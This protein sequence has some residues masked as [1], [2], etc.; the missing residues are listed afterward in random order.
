MNDATRDEVRF[1]A[2]RPWSRDFCRIVSWNIERGL[3][4]A[5]ILDFLRTVEADLLLLQEVDLNAR[6]TQYRD[7]ASDL[8][9]SLNFNYVFGMEFQE[10]SEGTRARPAFHGMATLSPWPLTKARLI[11]FHDQ[12]AF[13]KPHW[14]VPD[15]PV[16]QRRL[17]GRIALVAEAR[18]Y[19]QHVVT[20]NLHLESRGTDELRFRQLNDVLA[21]CRN[22]LN[23]PR[24]VVA[25]DFNLDAGAGDSA[26][27]LR[28][29]GF[30]DAVRLPG[31]VTSTP[32]VLSRARPIDW[33]FVSDAGESHGEVHHD[34]HASD[35]YP[36]S[37]TL[38]QP[39]APHRRTSDLSGEMRRSR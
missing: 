35:H 11:R 17:G 20:Y 10:L 25:G 13:W 34:V 3:Q 1:G 9:H 37:A 38:A 39:R 33:I 6:R 12:S 24:L 8:A 31:N 7:V 21:D 22:Y 5:K 16:F 23:R 26:K 18:I 29:A 14:Y 32:H 28:D 4:F 19:G 15:L 2:T 27:A 36:I 30:L